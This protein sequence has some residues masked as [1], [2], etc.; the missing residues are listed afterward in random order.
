MKM[1]AALLT[2]A[3]PANGHVPLLHCGDH[4]DQPEFHRRYEAYPDPS[5]RFELIG[6]V[7]FMMSPVGYDHNQ[8]DY[9][10][11]GLLFQYERATRGVEGAHNVTLILG[12]QSE[13]Q[14]DN[15]LMIRPECGGRVRIVKTG[16]KRYIHGPPELVFE[17][18]HSSL[19][20]DLYEKR[21]DYRQAG[22]MEYIVLEVEQDRVHWFDL[23]SGEAL[24]IPS[25]G[26]LRSRAFPGF[27]L[28]TKALRV[29]DVNRLADCLDAGLATTEHAQFVQELAA[30]KK[31]LKQPRGGKREKRD[32]T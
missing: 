23:R 30:R 12:P 4:L 11:T 16:K 8:G 3:G 32:A 28:D 20:I 5:V 25:D 7:V 18:A 21:S 17:V 13:P 10:I 6:G 15:A 22:V 29:R 19:A 27:W 24:A 31:S 1:P 26:I 9:R 14:P 2:K